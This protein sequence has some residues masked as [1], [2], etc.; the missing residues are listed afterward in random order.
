MST[1]WIPVVKALASEKP[2]SWFDLILRKYGSGDFS[3]VAPEDMAWLIAEVKRLRTERDEWREAA[4]HHE[5]CETDAWREVEA[6]VQRMRDL[7]RY[8]GNIMDPAAD[9][10]LASDL[11]AALDGES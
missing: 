8:T 1:D 2:V 7:P 6:T 4:Q 3:Y 9:Y 5:H 11:D 10:V